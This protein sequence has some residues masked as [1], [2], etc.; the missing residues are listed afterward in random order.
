MKEKVTIGACWDGGDYYSFD[1]VNRLYNSVERNTTHPFDFVLYTSPDALRNRDLK[2]INPNIKIVQTQLGW[3]WSGVH[4]WAKK[5]AGVRT[6]TLLYLDLDIVIIDNIDPLLEFPSAHAYMKDYPSRHCPKGLEGVGNCSVVLMRNGAGHEVWETYD[7]AG[8]PNWNPL[9]PPEDRLFP[10]SAQSILNDKKIPHDL[11][12][13]E[14]VASYKL[15]ILK[16]G[17]PLDCKIVSFHGRPKPHECTENW[18][19]RSW[20]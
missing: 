10:Y 16:R 15:E 20:V 19:V 14:W 9:D 12:P 4:L 8:R 18:I 11:F 5:P 3:W 2:L 1:Y 7:K 17:M 6:E 13:E